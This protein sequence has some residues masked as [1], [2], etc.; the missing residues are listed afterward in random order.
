MKRKGWKRNLDLK[1][2]VLIQNDN[3]YHLKSIFMNVI[4]GEIRGGANEF[5]GINN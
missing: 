1:W 3:Q 4:T 5:G 2:K